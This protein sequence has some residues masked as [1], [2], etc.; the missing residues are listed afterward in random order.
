VAG[1][2]LP[3]NYFDGFLNYLQT[4]LNLSLRTVRNYVGDLKGNLVTGEPKGFFQYLDLHKLSFPES[5]DK[6]IIRGFMAWV[7]DQGVVKNS[8]ARKLSAIRSLY[9]YLL[10]EESSMKARCPS[11]G[12]AAAACPP[13]P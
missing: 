3:E 2:P 12:G 10:R 6:Y 9:R 1:K 8:V 13:S 7:L 5:V 4:E 11:P